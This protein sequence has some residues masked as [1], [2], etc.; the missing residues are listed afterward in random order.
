MKKEIKQLQEE[1]KKQGAVFWVRT[2]TALVMRN[3]ITP[4]EYH[5]VYSIEYGNSDIGKI[6]EVINF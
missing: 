3:V 4:E 5:N 1:I 6:I 2:S